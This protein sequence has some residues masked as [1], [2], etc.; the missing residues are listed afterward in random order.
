VVPSISPLELL[1]WWKDKAE[2]CLSVMQP[3]RA[4][5]GRLGLCRFAE[6]ER[7]GRGKDQCDV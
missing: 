5:F 2:C 1:S 6:A 3:E 7:D 4:E